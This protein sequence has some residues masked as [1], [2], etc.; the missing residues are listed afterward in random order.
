MR[1]RDLTAAMT[2]VALLTACTGGQPPPHG[3]APAVTRIRLDRLPPEPAH[4]DELTPLPAAT[5]DPADP[6]QVAVRM[7]LDGL[8]AQDLRAV[9][10]GATT[11][12]ATSDRTTVRVAV[13]HTDGTGAHTSIYEVDLQQ[14][15][16][17]I[18]TV[19][20]SRAVG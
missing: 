13:T 14:A 6:V 9:D 11:I 4:P 10:V 18:W 2:A 19:V 12:T 3:G 20:G 5:A 15:D 8:D 7:L 1:A 17:G 16:D